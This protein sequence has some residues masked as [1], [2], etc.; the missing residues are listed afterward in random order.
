MSWSYW[1]NRMGWVRLSLLS[2]RYNIDKHRVSRILFWFIVHFLFKQTFCHYHTLGWPPVN[3]LLHSIHISL[4]C[5]WTRAQELCAGKH[6]TSNLVSLHDH[7]ENEFV[8]TQLA[9]HNAY[10]YAWIGYY[11]TQTCKKSI[12]SNH[13]EHKYITSYSYVTTALCEHLHWIL[14]N[15]FDAIKNHSRNHLFYDLQI[16]SFAIHTKPPKLQNLV[17]QKLMRNF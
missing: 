9:K 4:N 8:A 11:R 17:F 10:T 13:F 3:F 6:E 7:L 16:R 5:R 15:P 12:W 14:Y 1:R 2:V